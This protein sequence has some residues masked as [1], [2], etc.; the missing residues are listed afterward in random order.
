MTGVRYALGAAPLLAEHAA[1]LRRSSSAAYGR[2]LSASPFAFGKRLP[3][4]CGLLSAP[5]VPR[6]RLPGSLFRLIYGAVDGYSTSACRTATAARLGY[7]AI[8]DTPAPDSQQSSK[9]KSSRFH[10]NDSAGI[11]AGSGDYFLAY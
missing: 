2:A 8:A 1:Q 4:K 11:A 9:S 10:A 3:K 5:V 6:A 7:S